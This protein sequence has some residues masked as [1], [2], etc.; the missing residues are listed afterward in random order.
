MTPVNDLKIS[1]LLANKPTKQG[2]MG[3]VVFRI[4]KEMWKFSPTERKWVES[5]ALVIY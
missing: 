3:W 2:A 4:G 5:T 1:N